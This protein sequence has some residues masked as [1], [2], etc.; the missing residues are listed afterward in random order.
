MYSYRN[1]FAKNIHLYIKYQLEVDWIFKR[2]GF[3]QLLFG[4]NITLL[5]THFI[6]NFSS[7]K[8]QENPIPNHP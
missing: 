4:L 5:C 3:I 2:L 7:S 8:V 1:D 6:G